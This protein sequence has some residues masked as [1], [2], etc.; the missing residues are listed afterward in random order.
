MLRTGQWLHEAA[1]SQNLTTQFIGASYNGPVKRILPM[2][3]LMLVA[4]CKE[5]PIQIPI[6]DQSFS[7]A[8]AVMTAG[9][10]AFP[11]T[12]ATFKPPITLGSVG[13]SGQIA[14]T[15]S[16][17]LTVKIY[18]RSVAP[19]GCTDAGQLWLC[20]AVSETPI[21]NDIVFSG[22]AQ[23]FT[24]SGT[25]LTNGINKGELWLGIEVKSGATLNSTAN[26]TNLLASIAIL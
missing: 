21:S 14:I 10:V 26:L 11:K 2:L 4:A 7:F 5:M 1:Q 13:L 25:S 16:V 3:A 20:D 22:T 17:N 23:P 6:P 15:P 24:L 19:T 12:A 18:A 8:G 9:K